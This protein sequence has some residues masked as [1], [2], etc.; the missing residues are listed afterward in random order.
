MLPLIA[1]CQENGTW[2]GYTDMVTELALPT[3]AEKQVHEGGAA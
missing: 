3:W 1:A 2:P